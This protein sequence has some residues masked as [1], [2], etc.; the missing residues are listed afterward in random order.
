MSTGGVGHA[1]L[2]PAG[3]ARIDFAGPEAHAA[4]PF[5]CGFHDRAER[6]RRQEFHG[7]VTGTRAIMLTARDI[8]ARPITPSLN[9]P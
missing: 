9:E 7:S 1:A 3:L 2:A 5:L 4:P 8:G 6:P